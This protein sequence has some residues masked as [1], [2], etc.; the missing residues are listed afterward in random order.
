M[1][2]AKIAG[3]EEKV[4]IID[5]RVSEA[6]NRNSSTLSSIHKSYQKVQPE[7]EASQHVLFPD[8]PAGFLELGEFL[9]GWEDD[10]ATKVVP[11]IVCHM[12]TY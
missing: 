4:R 11:H 10:P 12:V 3:V 5:D 1:Q 7:V 6:L 2:I 9:Q 8:Q